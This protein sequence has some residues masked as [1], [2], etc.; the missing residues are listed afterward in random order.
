M[1]L[2]KAAIED[3]KLL[4]ITQ[5]QRGFHGDHLRLLQTDPDYMRRYAALFLA[6]G[7]GENLEKSNRC[8]VTAENVIQDTVTYWTW[9]W[10]LE[11][12]QKLET[13]SL[14][15]LRGCPSRALRPPSITSNSP[16]YLSQ[17]EQTQLQQSR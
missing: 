14:I 7:L 17:F 10:V 2:L 12:I 15:N 6:G 9:D 16:R 11:E 4:S 1:L 13:Y 8:F 3:Q 5:A